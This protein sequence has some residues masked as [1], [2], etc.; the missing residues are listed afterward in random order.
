MLIRGKTFKLTL[1][2]HTNKAD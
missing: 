1:I 2:C